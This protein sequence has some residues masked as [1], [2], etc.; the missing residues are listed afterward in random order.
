MASS[1][2]LLGPGGALL[3][4]ASACHDLGPDT[5]ATAGTYTIRELGSRTATGAYSFVLN[6]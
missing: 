3:D 2:Q 1:W 6:P 5:L 4:F